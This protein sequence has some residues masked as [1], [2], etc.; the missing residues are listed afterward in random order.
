MDFSYLECVY[1]E[2]F[3]NLD[4]IDIYNFI[5]VNKRINNFFYYL[6]KDK[7]L[8]NYIKMLYSNYNYKIIINDTILNNCIT[9]LITK[10]NISFIIHDP[11]IIIEVNKHINWSINYKNKHITGNFFVDPHNINLL[12]KHITKDHIFTQIIKFNYDNNL[13]DYSYYLIFFK[14][15]INKPVY[16][17]KKIPFWYTID[18]IKYLMNIIYFIS[19][20]FYIY[21]FF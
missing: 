21:F 13:N 5:I 3:Y 15:V 16:F 7:N 9:P 1:Q 19:L 11:N 10:N 6:S 17:F 20:L 12:N 14:I 2:F 4:A 8:L 18:I